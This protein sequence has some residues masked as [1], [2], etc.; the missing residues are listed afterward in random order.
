MDPLVGALVLGLFESNQV[1]YRTFFAAEAEHSSAAEAFQMVQSAD[2]LKYKEFLREFGC[3][4]LFAAYSPTE[5]ILSRAPELSYFAPYLARILDHF[6]QPDKSRKVRTDEEKSSERS[7]APDSAKPLCVPLFLPCPALEVLSVTEAAYSCLCIVFE[8]VEVEAQ[9]KKT[10]SGAVSWLSALLESERAWC[11]C[12]SQTVDINRKRAGRSPLFLLTSPRNLWTHEYSHWGLLVSPRIA[13]SNNNA[14][15]RA[16]LV[17]S[18]DLLPR[19]MMWMSRQS[20][21]QASIPMMTDIYT[22]LLVCLTESRA[23]PAEAEEILDLLREGK[24]FLWIP[25]S[26]P[27]T[28]SFHRSDLVWGTFLSLSNF[29]TDIPEDRTIFLPPGGPV[30]ALYQHYDKRNIAGLFCR[31]LAVP[32]SAVRADGVCRTCQAEGGRCGAAG[33]PLRNK[34]RGAQLCTCEDVGF[35]R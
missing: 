18:S 21:V 17:N 20:R 4:N 26:E 6:T 24:R 7:A 12:Y 15:L 27:T 14:L 9:G 30:K 25:D 11:P 33:L 1:A 10:G 8:L 32:H 34:M 23:P 3:V 2:K 29:I 31:S 16:P 35:G 28:N 19:L 13:T 22:K 5:R